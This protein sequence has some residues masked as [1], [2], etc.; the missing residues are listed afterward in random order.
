MYMSPIT[1]IQERM[2]IE[3]ENDIL[4]AV[5]RQNI[6]V[7]KEELLKALSYDREQYKKG[8]EDAEWE[9][10]EKLDRI[11]KQLEDEI[12]PKEIVVKGGRANGKTLRVGYNMGIV[13]A[14]EIVKAGGK[15]E[16]DTM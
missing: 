6:V 13:K 5:G 10:N 16:M 7:N 3:I 2:K 4:K 8:Y 9:F 1:I 11:V 14:I 15:N 12:T